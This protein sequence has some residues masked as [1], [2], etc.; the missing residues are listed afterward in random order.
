MVII[1]TEYFAPISTFSGLLDNETVFLESCE[2]YQKK[3]TRN[4]IQILG[5]N[6]PSTLS[7]P[8]VKGKNKATPIKDILISY[9]ENWQAK[10]L[11][12]IRSAYGSAPY[13][14]FYY[15]DIS[16]ILNAPHKRLWDLNWRIFNF[17][18]D[19]FS[20]DIQIHETTEYTKEYDKN[21]LDLRKGVTVNTQ[22]NYNQVFENK[23]GFVSNLSAL[24]LLMCKGPESMLY[25]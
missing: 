6:G 3:S 2:N 7:V 10:H 15:D 4:R 1:K 24:D 21:I 16:G 9:D 8:L 23:F 5:A 25:L 19:S 13:F 11:H 18:V 14:E 20:L 17:L 22:K 12:A